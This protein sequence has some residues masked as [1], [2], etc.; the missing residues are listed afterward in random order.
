MAEN[1]IEMCSPMR[2]YEP[3]ETTSEEDER[4]SIESQAKLK[5]DSKYEMSDI[6]QIIA[7]NGT[8]LCVH[9]MC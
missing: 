4:K 8:R 7:L 5:C 9:S 1:V 3:K 6:C 2:R